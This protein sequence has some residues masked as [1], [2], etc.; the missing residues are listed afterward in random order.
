MHWQIHSCMT[1]L[2]FSSS[3]DILTVALVSSSFLSSVL[4]HHNFIQHSAE[5]I[6]TTNAIVQCQKN[7]TISQYH[8]PFRTSM[9]VLKTKCFHSYQE[10]FSWFALNFSLISNTQCCLKECTGE[11]ESMI[12]GLISFFKDSNVG[13]FYTKI[14]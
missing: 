3:S 14:S 11:M 1:P 6:A 4:T 10:R 5:D 9:Q 13:F 12:L 2:T 7:I 8:F